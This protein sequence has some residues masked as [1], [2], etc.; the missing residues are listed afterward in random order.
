[1]R[2][3]V[4]SGEGRDILGIING[5]EQIGLGQV[6]DFDYVIREIEAIVRGRGMAQ[7]LRRKGT[8]SS[9]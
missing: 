4:G 6:H 5:R 2:Y 8:R 1:M 7:A 9:A 3:Y